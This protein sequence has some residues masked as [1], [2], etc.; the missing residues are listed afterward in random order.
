MPG[1]GPLSPSRA[2]APQWVLH[3]FGEWTGRPAVRVVTFNYLPDNAGRPGLLVVA[4]RRDGLPRSTAHR[5]VDDR[6]SEVRRV[7][8]SGVDDVGAMV[9]RTGVHR[10]YPATAQRALFR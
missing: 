5:V 3:D 2:A 8:R 10:C 4:D 9:V 1:N 6:H 7:F